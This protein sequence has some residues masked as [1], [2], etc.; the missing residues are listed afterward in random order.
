MTSGNLNWRGTLEGERISGTGTAG[1]HRWT[2]T[3]TPHGSSAA[4]ANGNGVG[5]GRG[6]GNAISNDVGTG[7][8]SGNGGGVSGRNGASG[9]SNASLTGSNW[10]AT[11]S[12]G[13]NYELTFLPGGTLRYT[14]REQDYTDGTWSQT[15]SNITFTLGVLGGLRFTG[16][17]NGAQMTGNGSMQDGHTWT[18]RARPATRSGST[19][20]IINHNPQSHLQLTA[21]HHAA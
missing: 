15:G 17:L 20:A 21:R 7:V 5:I 3:L 4:Q 1:E 2:F 14:F 8:G 19:A 6:Q 18:W 11:D 10:T 13:D 16:S 9:N 12:D